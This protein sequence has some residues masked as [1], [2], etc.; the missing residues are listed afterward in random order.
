MALS[1]GQRLGSYEVTAQIGAGGM[2]EVYEAR[3]TKLG[4]SGAIKVLPSAFVN[5]PERLARS[6]REARMLA[7]MNH[8]NIATIHGMEQSGGTSY[9]VM[10]FVSGETLQER[11]KRE[12]AIPMEEALVI[13][14]HIADALDV[15]HEKAIILRERK[16]ANVTPEGKF[17]VLDFCQAKAFADDTPSGNPSES[18]NL[19]GS[20]HSGLLLA[21]NLGGA[22]YEPP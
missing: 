2:V 19:I 13:A 12:G 6:Q 11:V 18:P 3:D 14:K 22:S 5:E 20:L 9:L 16:P 8:P 15:A 17:K 7:S 21:S 1:G 10:E 4:R